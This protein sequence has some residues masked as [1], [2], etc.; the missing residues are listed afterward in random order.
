[1]RQKLEAIVISERWSG[2]NSHYE[3]VPGCFSLEYICSN[4]IMVQFTKP[5]TKPKHTSQDELLLS[6]WLGG[7][8]WRTQNKTQSFSFQGSLNRYQLTLLIYPCSAAFQMGGTGPGCI[9]LYNGNT[10]SNIVW[11]LDDDQSGWTHLTNIKKPEKKD[12]LG[13]SPDCELESSESL[14]WWQWRWLVLVWTG[15]SLIGIP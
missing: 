12:V 8:S 3:L 11:I 5:R 2:V 15:S 14:R 1:M 6:I 4:I 7:G 13:M 10:T 9:L